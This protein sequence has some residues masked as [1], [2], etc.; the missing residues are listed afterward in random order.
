MP[1]E[2]KPDPAGTAAA[3]VAAHE[4]DTTSVHGIADTSALYRS[5]G[6]DVAVA[7]GGTGASDASTARTNLGL[8]TAAVQ[9]V[10]AFWQIAGASG[11]ATAYLNAGSGIAGR[12]DSTSHA[13]KG[14]ITFNGTAGG[15][16]ANGNL[17]FSTGVGSG[18]LQVTQFYVGAAGG[19]TI[20]SSGAGLVQLLNAAENGFTRLNFGPATTSFFSIVI[21]G[22]TCKIRNGTDADDADLTARYIQPRVGSGTTFAKAG[23]TIFNSFTDTAT[24]STDGTED[25][26][27][28]YT[29]VAN[30]FG[31]NGDKVVQTEHVSF[32]ASATASRRL[33][34]YFAGTLI[35]DSGALTLSLGGEFTI[36]TTIIRETSTVVRVS[37]AV[38]STS[39]S[40]LPYATYTRIT[41]LTLTGTNIL[42]TTGTASGAGAASSDIAN[43]L[44]NVMFHPA[45]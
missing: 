37:V 35:F 36:T 10:G 18:W 19:A 38:T 27:Y 17:I 6:T 32:V 7:D 22:T 28:S 43:K 9:N 41:G 31:T 29:T 24:T 12:I 21:S 11:Q 34:K 44:S 42:K 30:T 8:G 3:A 16:D 25:D 33:R 23:G 40:S 20:K 26:L 39:A 4:A 15:F 13:T 1:L 14:P 2:L 5:G 45:A